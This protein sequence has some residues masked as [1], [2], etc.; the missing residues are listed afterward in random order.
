[1]NGVVRLIVREENLVD[2]TSERT[3]GAIR[4]LAKSS[5]T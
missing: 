5:G 1:M 4:A 2:V 3:W